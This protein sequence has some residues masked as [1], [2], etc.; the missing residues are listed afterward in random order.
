MHD[1]SVQFHSQ[2]VDGTTLI[3]SWCLSDSFLLTNLYLLMTNLYLL[4]LS[5][6]DGEHEAEEASA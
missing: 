2:G 6:R 3:P 5:G 1:T 4:V